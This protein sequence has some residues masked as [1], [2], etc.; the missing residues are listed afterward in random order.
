MNNVID[1]LKKLKI[2]FEQYKKTFI[3][4][5]TDKWNSNYSDIPVTA[6]RRRLISNLYEYIFP[7]NDTVSEFRFE[8]WFDF[9][10][11]KDCNII[12]ND[13]MLEML[14]AYVG[15]IRRKKLDITYVLVFTNRIAEVMIQ[16]KE[17][18]KE[19]DTRVKKENI[20]IDDNKVLNKFEILKKQN[21]SIVMLNLYKG[22]PLNFNASILRVSENFT[23][24]KVHKYQALVM[25]L[26]HQTYLKLH[27]DEEVIKAIVVSV[28]MEKNLA[29]L[30]KFFQVG[31][32]AFDRSYVRVQPGGQIQVAVHL[33]N[34][35]LMGTLQEISVKGLSVDAV[36]LGY[37]RAGKVV[38]ISF[39]LPL[40]NSY[41]LADV[42]CTGK[43]LNISDG[44]N[45]YRMGIQ[46]FPDAYAEN[47][48]S[49]YIY[50]RQIE[51]IKELQF[52]TR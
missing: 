27:P 29:N 32:S 9:I 6:S 52:Y 26:E 36:Q 34:H 20:V 41:D 18:K 4:L 1:T 51:L 37:L 47:I 10:G 7:L 19:T 23:T 45:G 16:L 3:S 21:K 15:F 43:I 42:I 2:F 28:D 38:E 39:K 49:K 22:I 24:L 35:L 11:E 12:L 30:S 25:E 5:F 17:K 14:S 46:T 13:I 50:N 33:D 8:N 31:R 44:K 48:I 40:D